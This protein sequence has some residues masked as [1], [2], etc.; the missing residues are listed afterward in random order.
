[1]PTTDAGVVNPASVQVEYRPN[2]QPPPQQ[3]VHVTN[4]AACVAN[5]WYYDNNTTP[6]SINLCPTICGTVQGDANARVNVLLGCLG[7]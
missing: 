3:L 5:G 6:T 4:A 2:G 1:M 7:G